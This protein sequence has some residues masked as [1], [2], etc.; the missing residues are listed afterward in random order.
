MVNKRRSKATFGK[1]RETDD[2]VEKV[3]F[4]WYW[5]KLLLIFDPENCCNAKPSWI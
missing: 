3:V 1:S 4:F 2:E 5:K